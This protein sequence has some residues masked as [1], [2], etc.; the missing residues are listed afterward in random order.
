MSLINKLIKRNNYE[1]V[2]LTSQQKV[3]DARDRIER[4][5]SMFK[6]INNEI[7]DVNKELTD[8]IEKDKVIVEDIK[9]NIDNAE[10]ELQAN[11]ALQEKVSQ[12]IK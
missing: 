12:F 4:S 5:F 1:E 11:K 2:E 3:E 9:K 7:E 10:L 8:L 6:S